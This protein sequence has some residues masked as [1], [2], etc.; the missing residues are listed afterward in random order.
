M[1]R[2]PGTADS[3]QRSTSEVDELRRR[4]AEAEETLR[5]IRAGEVDALVVS[6]VKGEQVFALRGAEQPYRLLLESMNDGALSL[7]LDG[8]I[9]YS[10][11]RFAQMVRTPLEQVIGAR[12][13]H[14]VALDQR[15]RL[16]DLL[17]GGRHGKAQ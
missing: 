8:T 12:I 7:L 1:R 13:E 11:R 9:A 14:F 17:A 5:A 16:G 4:L 15:G 10:N 2:G 3:K 6:S